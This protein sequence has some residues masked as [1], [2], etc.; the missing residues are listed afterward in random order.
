MIGIIRNWCEGIIIAII[1]SVIIELLVPEGNNKKYVKVVIGIY[2]IFVI[3]N[4][5]LNLMN[6]KID[7]EYFENLKK[8][9]EN[10]EEVS[11]NFNS[12]MKDV[13]IIG[14]EQTI[15]NEVEKMGYIV[16]TV[17]VT[18]DNKYEN[19]ELIEISVEKKELNEIAIN[20]VSIGNN[21]SVKIYYEDIANF[22]IENYLVEESQIIFR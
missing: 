7:F 1:I 6:Y 5:L 4:P 3:I 17:E 22:L 12:D 21:E 14:I 19:I 9:E 11:S 8:F 18:V 20:T 2:I 10:S 13:Y 16:K 15:K